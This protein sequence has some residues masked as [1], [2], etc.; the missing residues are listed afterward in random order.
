MAI[1]SF[2]ME[3]SDKSEHKYLSI[4]LTHAFASPIEEKE[5]ADGQREEETNPTG[6]IFIFLPVLS[7][8]RIVAAFLFS[9]H[10]KVPQ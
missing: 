8:W 4:P 2:D 3:N 6:N 7:S 5:G 1:G 10:R 9:Q